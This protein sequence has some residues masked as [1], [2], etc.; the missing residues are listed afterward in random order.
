MYLH[1]TIHAIPVNPLIGK[2]EVWYQ[3]VI[4]TPSYC[5]D[6]LSFRSRM[7]ALTE[8]LKCVGLPMYSYIKGT[9]IL[10]VPSLGCS[11]R[12]KYDK[13]DL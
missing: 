2:G 12:M 11:I 10:E 3:C 7:E 8:C 6:K 1:G 9:Y 4:K 13:I 5:V